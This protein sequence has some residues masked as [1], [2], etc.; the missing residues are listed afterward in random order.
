MRI[1]WWGIQAGGLSVVWWDTWSGSLC[2]Q[3]SRVRAAEAER[4]IAAAGL[5]QDGVAEPVD[6]TA[7]RWVARHGDVPVYREPGQ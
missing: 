4:S 3:V 7:R 5:V 1:R 6:D 2:W